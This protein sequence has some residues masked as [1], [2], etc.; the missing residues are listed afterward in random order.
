MRHQPAGDGQHLLLAAGEQARPARRPV[1]QPR[2][3]VEQ[4]LHLGRVDRRPAPE[5]AEAD[6]L[7]DGELRED[8]PALRHQDEPSAGD[9]VGG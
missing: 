4:A 9:P 3:P 6:V 1:A 5:G 8:L 2:E 7:D